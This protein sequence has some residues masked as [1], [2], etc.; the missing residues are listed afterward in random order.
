MTPQELAAHYANDRLIH[1]GITASGVAEP[2]MRKG[3]WL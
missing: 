2:L 1:D 3:E